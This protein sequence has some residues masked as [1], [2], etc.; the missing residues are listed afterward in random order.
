MPKLCETI[1]ILKGVKSRVY[2]ALTAQD[3]LCQKPQLFNGM[4]KTYEPLN[5]ED[6]DKPDGETAL[7]QQ[8]TD[9]MLTGI[10]Q[11]LTELFDRTAT[12]EYGNTKAT[13]DVVVDGQ[14]LLQGAP[15]T[16]LLFLEKQLNDLHTAVG[17]MPVLSPE[18][19]WQSDPNRNCWV[20][21]TV[22]KVRT[23]KTPKVVFTATSKTTAKDG[24]VTEQ[25]QGQVVTEDLP[26]GY[27]N[28]IYFSAAL[29]ATRRKQL[30]GRILMLQ[31]AVKQAR[32]RAN[33]TAVENEKVAKPLLDWV[34]ME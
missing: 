25:Q 14:V 20:S 21:E 11:Q 29:P 13:G 26:V 31:D 15:A 4:S 8:R 30:C 19:T 18:F 2:S 16:Y 28:T 10:T 5:E 7:V 24:S 22:K 32:E 12:L 27:W 23:K 3:K 33:V 1:A 9:E 17:R 34:F 6:P